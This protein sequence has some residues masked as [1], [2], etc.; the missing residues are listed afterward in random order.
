M[1]VEKDQ[2]RHIKP[3]ESARYEL[4]RMGMQTA[5]KIRE[6]TT[7]STPLAVNAQARHSTES[8]LHEILKSRLLYLSICAGR[9]SMISTIEERNLEEWERRNVTE[10]LPVAKTASDVNVMR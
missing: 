9:V 4:L 10:I 2:A 5:N 3:R 8:V 7:V 1:K 6:T